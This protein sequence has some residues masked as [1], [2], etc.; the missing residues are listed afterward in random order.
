MDQLSQ[1]LEQLVE[2]ARGTW[3]IVIEDIDHQKSWSMN[4]DESFYA[5]S[6]IKLPIMAAVFAVA[7]RGELRLGDYLT[8]K[9]ED[10]V[11]GSGVL[12]H[13]SPGIKLP[14]QDLLTLMIIQSDNTATNILIDL[15]GVEQIQQT[16]LDL[17]MSHSSFH[18]KLMTVPVNTS[19]RNKIAASDISNLLKTFVTGKFV[20]L[21]ACEQMIDI[22]KKQ[23]VR[24][25]LPAFLPD[26]D[27]DIV[28]VKPE[29]EVANKSGW[30]TGIH[31]DV[32]IFYVGNR[33][34]IVTAFSRDCDTL[35]APITLA[36]MGQEVFSYMKGS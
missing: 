5:A 32:G 15:V 9:R 1:R 27:S 26:Q 30:V 8:L 14:I 11:G 12:Q 18:T 21:Y 31:H 20:S 33:T 7:E 16:M 36:K 35:V 19:G 17:G 2:E 13:L 24:N 34:M 28:G 10:I 4:G 23:Q 29:W 25:G 6:V 3:G 22:M